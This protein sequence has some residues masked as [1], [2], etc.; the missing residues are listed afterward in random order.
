MKEEMQSITMSIP[1]LLTP[2]I[3]VHHP[4][5]RRRAVTHNDILGRT[6]IALQGVRVGA[7]K[8]KVR[9]GETD[10]LRVLLTA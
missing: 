2:A 5:T 1:T 7:G 6:L 4:A 10:P 9:A 8:G 3:F